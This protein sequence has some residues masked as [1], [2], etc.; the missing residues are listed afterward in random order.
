[1]KSRAFFSLVLCAV[2]GVALA[3]QYRWTDSQGRVQIT[4]TPP[5]KGAKDVRKLGGAAGAPAAA[6]AAKP[7]APLPFEL[8][9]LQKD[10]PVSLYTAPGCKEPCDLA[11][12]LLNKR[13]IPFKEVQVWN[14]ETLAQLKS[15]ANTENVP[16]LQVG[17][18]TQNNYDPARYDV[19][20]DS[21]GYPAA[22]VYPARS[23]QAPAAPEGFEAPPVAEAEKPAETA[24]K[25]GPYDTS[26]L[27]G[28]APKQGPYDS[29]TLKGTPPKPGPYG[30]PGDSKK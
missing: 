23:Q 22:G 17:R 26:G 5:P 14:E 7:E 21:A 10:F 16:V 8:A 2:A 30:L 27:K 28:P 3:Q 19:L 15:V 1:M 9:R 12:N 6:P 11:R 24:G 13:G 18:S 25:A 4:D 20:L 29:S